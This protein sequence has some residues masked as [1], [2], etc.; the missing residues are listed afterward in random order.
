MKIKDLI[1]IRKRVPFVP[2]YELPF[3]G[4]TFYVG[5]SSAIELPV[6]PNASECIVYG[7]SAFFTTFGSKWLRTLMSTDNR[8][9]VPIGMINRS[10]IPTPR[11]KIPEG[12]KSIFINALSASAQRGSI[13]FFL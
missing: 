5:A 2:V 11:M 4:Y 8:Y 13:S 9:D 1:P 12:C 10:G 3:T 7:Q 6:P